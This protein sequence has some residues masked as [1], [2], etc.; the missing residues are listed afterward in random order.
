MRLLHIDGRS[1]SHAWRIAV[2][3]VLIALIMLLLWLA[4]AHGAVRHRPHAGSLNPALINAVADN[5]I[6]WMRDLLRSG[7]DPNVRGPD[8]T[9]PLM[10]AA[11]FGGAGAVR[12][13][14]QCGARAADVS[15]EH[16]T[17]LHSAAMS[18]NV[19]CA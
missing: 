14:L 4:P 9:T 2:E 6:A 17:A 16:W 8:G 15:T 11:Q 13:L 18:G 7:A 10:C 3:T 19:D 1:S 5:D 12:L